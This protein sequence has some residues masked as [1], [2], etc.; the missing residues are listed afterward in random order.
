MELNAPN[1]LIVSSISGIFHLFGACDGVETVGQ[2]RNRVA[3]THPDLAVLV[4]SLEERILEINAG[5]VCAAIFSAPC[6]LHFAAKRMAHELRSIA[7]AKD[8]HTAPE[9]I[10]VNAECLRVIDAVGTACQDDTNHIGIGYRKLV[11]RQYLAEGV[12]LAQAT[13][14]ELCGLRT[15]VKNNNLLLLHK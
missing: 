12:E 10:Q 1:R 15:E 13:C 11:V 4:E 6:R 14:N 3:V 8:G 9:L 5:E 7:N 2:S